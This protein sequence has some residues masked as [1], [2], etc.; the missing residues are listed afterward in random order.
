M[1]RR[2]VDGDT[3]ASPPKRMSRGDSKYEDADKFQSQEQERLDSIDLSGGL[4]HQQR[5]MRR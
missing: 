1:K 2:Y 3:D 4:I 5:D